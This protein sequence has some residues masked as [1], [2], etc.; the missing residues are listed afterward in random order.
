[1]GRNRRRG[2]DRARHRRAR[3]R[4][5]ATIVRLSR[6]ADLPVHPLLATALAQRGY[7][8]A[9][10]VQAA[11]LAP[12]LAGRDLLVSSQTGSGK[13]VAFGT[14]IADSLLAAPAAAAP[15]ALVV[16][17]TRELGVQVS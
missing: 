16:A 11:V 1:M 5:C 7:E 13:T 17:P 6:F 8:T 10:P 12:E 9:T 3:P 14:L 4:D 15:R 2:G